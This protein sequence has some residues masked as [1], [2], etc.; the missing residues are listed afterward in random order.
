VLPGFNESVSVERGPLVYSLKLG[1]QWQ[2]LRERP[3]QADDYEVHPTTPWNYGL[4]LPTGPALSTAFKVKEL[5]TSGVLF[6]PAGAPV[7]LQ[8]RGVRLPS[9]QLADNSAG[10][11]PLSPV[12]KPA[13]AT[14]ETLTLIPYGS[15]KLRITSFPVVHP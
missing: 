12:A 3:T 5:P 6:S 2:K 15:A 4:L 11:P 1:E 13:G 9:W 7:E 8:V 10:P 14:V